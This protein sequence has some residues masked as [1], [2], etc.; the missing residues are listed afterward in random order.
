[1]HIQAAR[2]SD[3]QRWQRRLRQYLPSQSDNGVSY[4]V[5]ST[6]IPYILNFETI[7]MPYGAPA[8][9]ASLI[10]AQECALWYCIQAYKISVTSNQL[11]QRTIETWSQVTFP[12]DPEGDD[13]NGT[14]VS[15][16]MPSSM[17]VNRGAT[18][19]VGVNSWH[20]SQA[21]FQNIFS[22]V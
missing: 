4:N 19:F 6:T 15:T 10:S 1:M 21:G 14:I 20:G 22:Q 17:N 9:D 2:R 16:D 5:S 11:D 13:V 8:W 7:G 12:P 18:Y 3:S